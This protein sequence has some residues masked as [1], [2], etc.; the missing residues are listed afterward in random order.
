MWLRD[1]PE[2]FPWEIN[3]I[4]KETKTEAW[5]STDKITD[6]EK[7]KILCK[8][9]TS[10]EQRIL[11]LAKKQN[12]EWSNAKWFN[13][14]WDTSRKIEQY[15]KDWI[16]D[17]VEIMNINEFLD[18]LIK[19]FDT[20]NNSFWEKDFDKEDKNV[21]NEMIINWIEKNSCWPYAIATMIKL[22]GKNPDIPKILEYA[23]PWITWTWPNDMEK[24]IKVTVWQCKVESDFNNFDEYFGKLTVPCITKIDT[25]IFNQHYI[26]ISEM[27]WDTIKTTDWLSI[28]KDDMKKFVWPK[29]WTIWKCN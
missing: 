25:G 3:E 21:I 12:K 24:A 23:K 17:K 9:F 18:K 10:I 28:K 1:R 8:N 11:E 7:V 6:A 20:F 19:W 2:S 27:F 16:L 26:C 29:W 4:T 22:L 13:L 5:T 15:F 14:V